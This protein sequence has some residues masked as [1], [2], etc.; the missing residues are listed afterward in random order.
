[1]PSYHNPFALVKAFGPF[2]KAIFIAFRVRPLPTWPSP[3]SSS[4]FFPG[5]AH[6]QEYRLSRFLANPLARRSLP[7]E[8]TRSNIPH[9]A[10]LVKGFGHQFRIFFSGP[11]PRLAAFRLPGPW[12][13]AG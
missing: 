12:D 4:G 1:M 7:R 2:Q 8:T 10:A 13:N 3:R 9:R 11:V 6:R 5:Y